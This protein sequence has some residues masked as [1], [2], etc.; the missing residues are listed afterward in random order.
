MHRFSLLRHPVVVVLLCLCM[1]VSLSGCIGSF[2]LTR[3]LYSFND[4]VSE[5]QW[6]QEL[7]FLGLAV[8]PVYAVS[9]FGDLLLFNSIEF[10]TGNNP[11]GVQSSMATSP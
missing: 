11:V 2:N 4:E 5:N 1:L 6:T 7:V 10:W 9:L 8:I 3:T